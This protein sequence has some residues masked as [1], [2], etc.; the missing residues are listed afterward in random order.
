[1]SHPRAMR[2]WRQRRLALQTGKYSPAGLFRRSVDAR[3]RDNVH[4]TL[5]LDV[6]LRADEA[7]VLRRARCDKAQLLGLLARR[8][9]F[10]SFPCPPRIRA[11][12]SSVAV[13]QGC[14]RR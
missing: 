10:P 8:E 1:M 2:R 12:S 6:A 9:A 3:K 13:R 14:L 5:T 11:R 7:L 4:F